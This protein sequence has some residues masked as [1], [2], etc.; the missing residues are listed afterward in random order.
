MLRSL[1]IVAFV[2]F[3]CC[4]QV[5]AGEIIRYDHPSYLPNHDIPI[6]GEKGVKHYLEQ[7]EGKV[8]L[9]VFWATWCATCAD[10]VKSL[11]ILQKDFR[12]LPFVLL[13]V[14]EDYQDITAIRQ[15]YSRLGVKQLP[16][17]SDYRNKLFQ[18]LNITSLPTA[19][20][21][22]RDGRLVMKFLGNTNW[23]DDEVRRLILTYIPG[24]EIAP[25]NTSS[26]Q[27]LEYQHGPMSRNIKQ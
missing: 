6:N 18:G 5:N 3:S 16:V 4:C 19:L 23:S 2:L 25:R 26:K 7:Y 17:L 21:I 27:M 11:D 8:V 12:K 10:E 20:L 22:D 14:S 13:A 1:C 24:G 15:Y 9:L